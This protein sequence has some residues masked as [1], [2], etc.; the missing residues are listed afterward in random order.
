MMALYS[1]ENQIEARLLG[2]QDNKLLEHR[3]ME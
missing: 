3:R 2:V 1:N